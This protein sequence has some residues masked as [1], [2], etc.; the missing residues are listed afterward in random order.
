MQT[1]K[2]TI[3]NSSSA[4]TINQRYKV[5]DVV[6]QGGNVY[7]NKTGANSEPSLLIDW[8]LIS[9]SSSGITSYS[10]DFG[11]VDTNVFTVPSN[12]VIVSVLFN[13]FDTTN[14]LVSG[15]DLTIS[16]TLVDGDFINV[17]G[18]LV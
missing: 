2:Q 16:D 5:N 3:T 13:G 17:R 11:Y 8:I 18:I 12:L 6:T 9:N 14:Y 10:N 1:Q 7:Q 4:W 15:T